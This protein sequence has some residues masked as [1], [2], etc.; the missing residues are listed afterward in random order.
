MEVCPSIKI[1]DEKI[2]SVISLV[3]IDCLVVSWVPIVWPSNGESPTQYSLTRSKTELGN[4]LMYSGLKLGEVKHDFNL[5]D[6]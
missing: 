6:N 4:R 1:T 5:I 2:L 3:F